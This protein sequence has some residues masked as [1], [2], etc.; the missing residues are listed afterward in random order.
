MATNPAESSTVFF[1]RVT[2]LGLGDIR[3]KFQSRGWTSFADFAMACSDFSGRDNV[4]FTNDVVKPL[5]GEDTARLPKVRRLFAQAYA[6][7]SSFITNLDT[8]AAPDKPVVMHPLDRDDSLKKV[9]ARLTGLIIEGDTEPSFA[10]TDKY[11]TT[12]TNG[13]SDTILGIRARTEHRRLIM[14]TLHPG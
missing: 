6:V 3:D 13:K 2:E 7:H 4:A 5:I 14:L 12:L 11:A 9:K 8:P 10:L 1:S